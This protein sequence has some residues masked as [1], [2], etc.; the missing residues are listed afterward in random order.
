MADIN[1]RQIYTLFTFHLDLSD[2]GQSIYNTLY[3]ISISDIHQREKL[4]LV[5]QFLIEHAD[6]I[7][8]EKSDFRQISRLLTS[9]EIEWIGV[10]SPSDMQ[11]IE[12]QI[13]SYRETKKAISNNIPGLWTQENSHDFL[14]RLF[15]VEVKLLA[16]Y[17]NDIT[18]DITDTDKIR[19]IPLENEALYKATFE[20]SELHARR[21]EERISINKNKNINMTHEQISAFENLINTFYDEK[22]TPA[23]IDLQELEK[24]LTINKIE[25]PEVR[26]EL[27]DLVDFEN[28]LN[29]ETIAMDQKRDEFVVQ[30]IL[31][32]EGNG[33]VLR[34]LAHQQ[35]IESGL[36]QVCLDSRDL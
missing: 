32:Q 6:T 7:N 30:E 28:E 25:N 19:V 11:I 33:L 24:F 8:F 3:N 13:E 34:G 15:P 22:G 2:G 5:H 10:E 31:K 4:A 14:Y 16:E 12:Q 27:T 20:L 21:A 26:K 23:L 18:L 1:G 36:T 35:N 29:L 17:P 9:Q